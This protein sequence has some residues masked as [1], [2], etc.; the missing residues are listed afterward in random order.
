[1]GAGRSVLRRVHV[2]GG[3][4]H[5]AGIRKTMDHRTIM[6]GIIVRIALG[7]FGCLT[8]AMLLLAL[9]NDKGAFAVNAQS[10]KLAAIE[11][12]NKTLDFENLK[13][14]EYNKALQSDPA[15]IEKKAR[16]ELNLVR[17]GDVIIVTPGAPTTP[18]PT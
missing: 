9:F 3:F 7:V 1:H 18:D 12:E 15:T 5:I 11:K 4:G 13:L 17:P 16:E 8:V 14:N 10:L 2:H 6:Q